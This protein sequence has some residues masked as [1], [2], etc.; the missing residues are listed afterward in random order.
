METLSV[1][2]RT[3]SP[4]QWTKDMDR[5]SAAAHCVWKKDSLLLLIHEENGDAEIRRRLK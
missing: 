2:A 3:K 5:S 4:H 1:T